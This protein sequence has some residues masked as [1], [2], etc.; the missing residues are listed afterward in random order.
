MKSIGINQGSINVFSVR[1]EKN[2]SPIEVPDQ[3]GYIEKL[4]C[5]DCFSKVLNGS[6]VKSEV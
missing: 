1:L 6:G 2:L 4:A 3:A 5:Q